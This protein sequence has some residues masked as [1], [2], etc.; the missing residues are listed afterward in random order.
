[1]FLTESVKLKLPV[2]PCR[3]KQLEL[4]YN[5]TYVLLCQKQKT[6]ACDIFHVDKKGKV[7]QTYLE[8]TAIEKVYMPAHDQLLIPMNWND[9]ILIINLRKKQ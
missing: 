8:N 2:N 3:I 5:S 6:K 9:K 4:A 7:L 1:M